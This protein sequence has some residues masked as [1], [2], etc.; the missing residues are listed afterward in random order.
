LCKVAKTPAD[1]GVV[2]AGGYTR[3]PGRMA[4]DR[5][6]RTI[7]IIEDDVVARDALARLLTLEGYNIRLA[8]NGWEAL[9]NVGEHP[10]HLIVLD[11]MLPG[12]DGFTFLSSLRA[13]RTFQSIP[14][15]V[16]TALD[17]RK[18]SARLRA[19]GVNHVI[20]KNDT[21]FPK[22]QAAIKK[23]VGKPHPH[24]RVTL[25]DRGFAIRPFLDMY[26]KM[27]ACN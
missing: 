24:A 3:D 16:L 5:E 1:A 13:Q 2:V 9:L 23:V 20:A 22:L 26:L 25:P 15:I 27:L 8:S 17:V 11:M 7:L 21:S 14:V 19:L 12:M 4:K 18:I 10:P 6:Q